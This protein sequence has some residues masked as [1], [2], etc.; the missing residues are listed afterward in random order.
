MIFAKLIAISWHARY[1]NTRRNS[2]QREAAHGRSLTLNPSAF[3]RFI[4]LRYRERARSLLRQ[5][6]RHNGKAGKR[7]TPIGAAF[8]HKEGPAFSIEL[9]AF[10]VDGRLVVLAPDSDDR[11][12]K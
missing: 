10:P 8:P 9:K 1:Q 2:P 5:G 3:P 7:W 12:N 4:S 11:S 6:T